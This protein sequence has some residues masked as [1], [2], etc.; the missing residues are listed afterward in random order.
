M[1]QLSILGTGNWAH[2]IGWA[3]IHSLWQAAV[4]WAVMQIVYRCFQEMSARVKH[5]IALMGMLLLVLWVVN[6]GISQWQQM[7]VATVH[8]IPGDLNQAPGYAVEVP[9]NGAKHTDTSMVAQVYQAMPWLLACYGL[10]LLIML[11]RLG[12]GI[13]QVRKLRRNSW[14][15]KDAWV[16]DLAE[17]LRLELGIG[18]EVLLRVSTHVIAPIVVGVL[19]PMILLPATMLED[20]S[21][22]EI[23]T[24][25]LHE[26]AHISRAD[27]CINMI[28]SIIEIVLFFNPFMW[29]ISNTIRTEREHCCD[30]VVVTQSGQALTYARAL[31]SIARHSKSNSMQLA[32]AADGNKNSTLLYNR[33]KRIVEMKKHHMPSGQV[34]AACSLSAMLIALSIVC[35]SPSHAQDSKKSKQANT[36]PQNNNAKN[37]SHYIVID[38]NG[39]KTEYKDEEAMPA[40]RRVA[41]RRSM[42]ALEDTLRRLE[43]LGP[44]IEKSMAALEK[45]MDEDISKSVEHALASVNWEDIGRQVDSALEQADWSQIE[46]DVAHGLR[47]A[48]RHLNDPK[49][50]AEIRHAMA[51]A[52]K[53]ALVARRHAQHEHTQAM[54][55]ARRSMEEARRDMEYKRRELEAA[56]RELERA[57]RAIERARRNTREY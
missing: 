33:I 29:K 35:F 24:I 2:A 34:I 40:G 56:Q 8:V 26:L 14:L 57:Q 45:V 22:D 46:R 10:G 32:I 4:I 55:E 3:L 20:L 43:H 9:A 48:D 53:D 19:R 31:A 17:A 21:P 1:L 41:F 51:T 42:A 50:R 18:Q 15:P 16:N 44:R 27:Y 39:V 54:A 38:S 25:L 7:Q 30:D 5:G 37:Y 23:K 12:N 28:Q 13:L 47:E 6:T 52:R 11:F 49:I 36:Q